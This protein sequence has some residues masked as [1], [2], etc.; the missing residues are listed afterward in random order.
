L[1]SDQQ[2]SGGPDDWLAQAQAQ[3][4]AQTPQL[5]LT[6]PPP[7]LKQGLTCTLE[8]SQLS[9]ALPGTDTVCS[10]LRISNN[11]AVQVHS[12]QLVWQ[13]PDGSLATA[14]APMGATLVGGGGG[15]GACGRWLPAHAV[16]A[17]TSGHDLTARC[18][19]TTTAMAPAPCSSSTS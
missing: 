7:A 6:W 15:P 19:Q 10:V 17:L 16:R 11:L 5:Q 18:P 2:R 4:S 9:V 8:L 1:A 3:A 12:W 14:A 13:V